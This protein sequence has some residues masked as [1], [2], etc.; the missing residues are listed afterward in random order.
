MALNQPN[1]QAIKYEFGYTPT[2]FES[3]QK[4]KNDLIEKMDQHPNQQFYLFFNNITMDSAYRHHLET[5]AIRHNR[6]IKCLD[7]I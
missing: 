1:K 2:S 7:L 4:L 5:I 6:K 3:F